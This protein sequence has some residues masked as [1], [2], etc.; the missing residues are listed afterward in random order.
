[1]H[2]TEQISSPAP[3]FSPP[4]PR[5]LALRYPASWVGTC[6]PLAAVTQRAVGE[7]LAELGYIR[8][9]LSAQKFAR[10]AVGNYGGW[11]YPN[12]GQEELFTVTAFLTWWI[13]YDDLAEGAAE[14]S[15]EPLV[16][17]A[18]GEPHDRSPASP[19]VRGVWE[20]AQRYRHRMSARWL[21]RHAERFGDWLRG[22]QDEAQLAAQFRSGRCVDMAQRYWAVRL[23]N[24]GM[25][26]MIDFIEYDL[27]EELPAALWQHPELQRIERAACAL[28]T[29]INDL[30]GYTKDRDDC[31]PNLVS[32]TA[33]E[34]GISMS[35]AF[36]EI[37]RMHQALLTELERA[38][39]RLLSASGCPAL[40]PRFC[41]RLHSVI[42]GF[43]RWHESAP[44]YKR[45]HSCPEGDQIALE[46][47][48]S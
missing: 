30:Y 10:L 14:R 45:V 37:E 11:P 26:P 21:N 5:I 29:L 41:E 44:R 20:L 18:R 48:A 36:A 24:I 6:N 16:A 8:D 32:C 27:G 31:W 39:Q 47:S 42:Y 9:D 43:A 12:A 4:S 25:L 7:W 3:V 2:T 19:L 34:R 40:L 38:E 22:L 17:A 28:V 33:R 13:F 35:A 1:M 15:I 23:I 46:V